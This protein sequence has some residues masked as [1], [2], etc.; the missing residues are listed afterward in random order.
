MTL[1]IPKL[2]RFPAPT[3]DDSEA[4]HQFFPVADRLY[5]EQYAELNRLDM[6][7][8]RWV[9]V[10]DWPYG[11]PYDGVKDSTAGIQSALDSG[12]PTCVLTEGNYLI[13]DTLTIPSNVTFVIDNGAT[14]KLADGVDKKMITNSD[15][16]GGNTNINVLGLGT[17]DGNNTNQTQ[18]VNNPVIFMQN[19]TNGSIRDFTIKNGISTGMNVQ[20]SINIKMSGV[21]MFTCWRN[22]VNLD[23]CTYIFIDEFYFKDIGSRDDT[24]GF[25]NAGHA[26]IGSVDPSS[27]VTVTNSKARNCGDSN[28]RAASGCTHWAIASNISVDAGKDAFKSTDSFYIK[29]WG[30]LAK[31]AGNS[32]LVLDGGG[33]SAD[34]ELIAN[35]VDTTDQN[36]DK[37]LGGDGVGVVGNGHIVALN[38]VLNAGRYGMSVNA[39]DCEIVENQIEY[40]Q[41]DGLQLWNS[42]NNGVKGNRC[43]NNSR[44]SAGAHHGI[45]VNG[46]SEDN[47]L[48]DNRCFDDEGV[49]TQSWGIRLGNT[50]DNNLLNDNHCR[51]NLNGGIIDQSSG[52]NN[53]AHDN[54]TGDSINVASV[55]TVTLPL[56]GEFFN[57]TG[58]TTITSVAASWAKRKVTLK[59]AGILTFTDGSNLKLAGNF[60]TTA[61]DVIDL[62]CDGTNWF[63]RS[64]SVN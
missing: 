38:K 12:N 1:K 11:T 33:V 48:T 21:S 37:T 46:T 58:V 31:N 35:T 34:C 7:L 18:G 50:A 10:K 27:Y 25:A 55:A 16:V 61:D 52:T 43:K 8:S 4:L 13:S 57:I 64:R 63:E 54:K 60:V 42:N 3:R 29:F 23:G 17:L 22:G 45:E 19:V 6:L 26:V 49:K 40:S 59:F 51:G 32:G 53:E 47:S 24:T 5:Q 36:P 44:A 30:N 9:D 56:D 39:N 28:F 2:Y 62:V 20:D 41:E 14:L 15:L